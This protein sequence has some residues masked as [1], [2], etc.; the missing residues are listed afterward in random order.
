M[1]LPDSTQSEA[2]IVGLFYENLIA[3]VNNLRYG[4]SRS[5]LRGGKIVWEDGEEKLI[6]TTSND[7]LKE[8]MDFVQK[9]VPNIKHDLIVLTPITGNKNYINWVKKQTVT[10][11]IAAK[12]E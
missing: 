3:D 4:M 2:L 12:M 10:R 7:R 6:M 8:L 9:K 5:F 1:T 11:E